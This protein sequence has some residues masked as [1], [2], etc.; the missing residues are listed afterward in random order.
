MKSI[1]KKYLVAC[2]DSFTQGHIMGK[3][4]SWA[5][6]VGK[7]LQLRTVNI[8]VGG[9]SNDWIC[10]TTLTWLMQNKEK[11]KDSVV[12]IGWSD[13]GRQYSVFQPVIETDFPNT[14]WETTISPADFSPNFVDLNDPTIPQ[15]L[16]EIEI[17]KDALIPWFGSF[18]DCLLKTYR[19]I[20]FVKEYCE[21]NDIPYI[22]F[23]MIDNQKGFFKRNKVSVRNRIDNKD[24]S[25]SYLDLGIVRDDQKYLLN[26]KT[27]SYLFDK[28]YCH[29]KDDNSLLGQLENYPQDTLGGHDGGYVKGNQGHLNIEGSKWFSEYVVKWFNTLYKL[30]PKLI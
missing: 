3:D 29:I 4:A 7:T 2:G 8:A 12:M 6:Y 11:A 10:N 16:K 5:T 13:F 30:E 9:M 21:S 1:N 22:M 24:G 25:H 19:S 18:T 17:N 15:A 14:R 27:T 26:P 23:D 28:H 20:L